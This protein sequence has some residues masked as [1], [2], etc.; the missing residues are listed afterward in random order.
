MN[1]YIFILKNET[2]K[3]IKVIDVQ[4]LYNSLEIEATTPSTIKITSDTYTHVLKNI[5]LG[6]LIYSPLSSVGKV[7]KNK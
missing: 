2:I 7:W 4:K 6:V 1:K 3:N 5:K